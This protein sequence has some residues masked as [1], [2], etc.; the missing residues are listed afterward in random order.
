MLERRAGGGK[1][2]KQGESQS[3]SH[4]LILRFWIVFSLQEDNY[5]RVSEASFECYSSACYT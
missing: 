5:I 4:L 3:P 2:N 1:E